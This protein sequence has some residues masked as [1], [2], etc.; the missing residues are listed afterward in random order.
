[1]WDRIRL[2]NA[3][4]PHS[5]GEYVLYWAR[6][7]RRIDYNHALAFAVETAN[8][9]RLPVLFYEH[10][11]CAGPYSSDRFHA[12]I[13]E[14][15]RDNA[16]RAE[17]L[18]I[19]YHFHLRRT[20]LHSEGPL[21]ML[22]SRAAALVTDDHP[23]CQE[24]LPPAAG[25]RVPFYAVDSSCIVPMRRL[26]NRQYAA[27]SIRPRIKRL[28]PQ[29]M[30]PLRMPTA[31]ARWAAPPVVPR[32][33][34]AS[35]DIDHSVKP[36]LTFRGGPAAA[37]RL[38]DHF[39]QNGLRRY[40]RDRKEPSA[41]A[42][43]GMSPYLHFGHISALEIALAA[44]AYAREHKLIADEYLEEII[45]R[46]EL[47]FNFA[48]HAEKPD[49]LANL[50]RWARETLRRHSKDVRDPCYTREVFENACTHDALWNATQKELM[51]R[52]KI[53]GYY[54]MYWGKKIIEWSATCQD[55]LETM[56]HLHDRYALDGRDPNT[57]TNI[58]WCFGL[59]DRPWSERPV[60]GTIRYMSFDGMK[61]KTDVDEY[62]REIGLLERTGKDPY[63][64]W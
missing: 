64:L 13:L 14:G 3:A 6:M 1:M 18:G 42:T 52:G 29:Y 10:L 46:R 41:H 30:M 27:Y 19:G 37:R 45:V 26:E 53:H 22:I 49:T 60:F 62:L 28:L 24:R 34:Y 40:A 61:R 9:R 25:I 20:F 7:N 23:L 12:F 2:L 54:R 17:Q 38:L 55:A 21:T 11:S 36:S 15:V 31:I 47:A 59:H 39:L 16:R 4:P 50:P 35:S 63:R 48:C 51:L 58:L 33:D 8:L 43:S 32:L 44:E 57:Y 56:V 5:E